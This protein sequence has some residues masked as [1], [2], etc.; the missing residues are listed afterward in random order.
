MTYDAVLLVGFGG[1]TRPEEIRPFLA[2]VLRG[3]PVS[4][5][6]VEEVV[7]HYEVI[8]GRSPFNELTFQQAQG[9]RELLKHQG[10]D[11]PVYVGMRNW[12]PLLPDTMEQM[13]REDVKR[14]LGIILAP[15]QGEASWG[16]YRAAVKEAQ[17]QLQSNLCAPAPR[18]DYS[19]AWFKHPLFIE[20]AA[21]RL[22]HK[23]S[24]IPPNRREG[25][26]LLFTAHSVP[27]SA[28]NPY[29]D[30]LLESCAA[31]AE[32]VDCL[33]WELVYQS[34]SGRSQDPWLE[35][36]VCEVIQRLPSLG[37]KDVVI[38]PIG[39]V[40]DHVEVLFDLDVEARQAA[41]EKGM[42]FYR[43]GTVSNHPSFIGVLA[44]LLRRAQ[45]GYV[46]A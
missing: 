28:A 5:E 33:G 41:E 6:R 2:N 17:S 3:R 43:A 10:P 38:A 30:Q 15:H 29:V 26:K 16:R 35:P 27:T 18:I 19:E 36:D 40:S 34:R 45:Q 20:A 23:M 12:H 31:V 24:D 11:L 44:D 25:A 37:Y 7:H 14:A 21:D 1:P 4:P 32:Q 13:I 39:F 42:G 46:S 9:L 8:G 22:R